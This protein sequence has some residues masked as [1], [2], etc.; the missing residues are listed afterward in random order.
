MT[1]R[2]G[3]ASMSLGRTGLHDLTDK[4]QDAA[5]CGFEGI[6]MFYDDLHC[7]AQS[8][9]KGCLTSAAHHIRQ[10]CDSLRLT[11]IC[12]QP[13]T[14]YEG[15]TDREEHERMVQ[16]K[17]FLW[18]QLAHILNTDLI[19]VPANFLAPDPQTGRARTTGDRAVIVSD[20]QRIADMGQQQSPPIRFAYEALCWST[21]VDTWEASWEV[22]QRVDRA[23]FGLCLDTFNIAGRVYADPASPTGK[24]STAEEDIQTS[25][26]R[27]LATVDVKKVFYV[28]VI[29]GERLSAPLNVSHKFYV[30]GQP[31]RMSWSRN[32]R[33][34]PFEEDRGGYLPVIALAQ[35]ILRLVTRD[36]CR[37][38]SSRE[39]SQTRV[40][41]RP[42]STPD[43]GSSRSTS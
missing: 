9:F 36:G 22:V 43:G 41:G 6:E 23:N 39:H 37:L 13:F 11:V 28:E 19:Q 42:Q 12:L 21:H 2:P 26:E 30:P 34:F 18:F 7:H 33:L 20:L 14:F 16:D 29:D 4:L 17:L 5:V 25:M 3:I 31:S 32:A 35:T 40:R 24:T 15:L 38:S 27:L 10:V 1:L 8:K